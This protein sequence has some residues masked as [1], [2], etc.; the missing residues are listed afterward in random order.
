MEDLFM[1]QALQYKLLSFH[2]LV[3]L[4]LPLWGMEV[5]CILTIP[6]RVSLQAISR[7]QI[8]LLDNLEASFM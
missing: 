1:S 5:W 3:S 4:I 8:Q 2:K 6:G 7:S